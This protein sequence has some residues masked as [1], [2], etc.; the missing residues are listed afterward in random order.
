MANW[1]YADGLE[2]RG[3]VSEDELRA[4]AR[5]G[6][7]TQNTYVVP[8]GNTLWVLLGSAE[9]R[10][11]L[12]RSATGGYDPATT[13]PTDTTPTDTTPTASFFA[14]STGPCSMCTST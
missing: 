7:L 12:V 10:L 14:V 11:G 6:D 8:Q 2:T 5:R 9:T 4:M 1:Y 3:P 13:T